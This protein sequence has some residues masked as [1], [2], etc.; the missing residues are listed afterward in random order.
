MGN[1]VSIEQSFSSHVLVSNFIFYASFT[2]NTVPGYPTHPPP[3]NYP[4]P[5]Q[6]AYGYPQYPPY[7]PPK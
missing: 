1:N 2:D 7:Q 3:Q 6:P 5:Q 4:Y